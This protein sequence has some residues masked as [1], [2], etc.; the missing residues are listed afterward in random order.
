[1]TEYRLSRLA[2]LDLE[3]I[4]DYTVDRWG[5]VQADRYL[6]GLV[7][8]FELIARRPELGRRCD[9]VRHGYR[10]IE[11]GKHIVIFRPADQGV[12][13]SRILHQSMLPEKH[14]IDEE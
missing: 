3:E 2:Q 14:L 4:L 6:S 9:E 11:Q 7:K 13:I 1:L 12:F 5:D 8:C 10:R